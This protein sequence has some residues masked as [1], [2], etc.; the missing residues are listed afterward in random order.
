MQLLFVGLFTVATVISAL[1]AAV[2][3]PP[4]AAPLPPV[5]AP[6]PPAGPSA[7]GASVLP[8]CE[9]PMFVDMLPVPARAEI[10]RIW[11]TYIEGDCTSHHEATKAVLDALPP[12]PAAP[13]GPPCGLPPMSE[14]LPTD[15]KVGIEKIWEG[16]VE[17]E[18]CF[19]QLEATQA[20]LDVMNK[21]VM[22]KYNIPMPPPPCGLPPFAANLPEDI[23]P[24][25]EQI[26]AD[27][28]YPNDCTNEHAATKALIDQL[29]QEVK[30]RILP[31]GPPPPP[32]MNKLPS[33]LPSDQSDN[34]PP[35]P[36][37][38]RPQF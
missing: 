15:T 14:M 17:G 4:V 19:T 9:T 13:P 11:S 36:P 2:P 24:L 37:N 25:V 7:P 27:Y 6:L 3:L 33:D 31:P 23:K 35:P 30:A 28:E 21:L 29:P 8:P 20:F 18:E 38:A 22:E 32:P 5:A 1:P 26:W 10:K 34:P 16:Y 12:P